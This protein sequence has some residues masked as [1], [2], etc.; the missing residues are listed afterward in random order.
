MGLP[1]ADS[2]VC[3]AFRTRPWRRSD[4]AA[5]GCAPPTTCR[6]TRCTNA[7][8]FV[9][10]NVLIYA[11]ST[12]DED[13]A[14]RNQALTVLSARDLALS[15]QV[16]QEF[17]VQSTR[18]SRPGALSHHEATSFVESLLR[19]RVQE[20]TLGV[21]RAAFAGRAGSLAAA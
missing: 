9:D 1:K 4:P 13:A 18:Q 2:T 20:L 5:A 21:L 11:V 8:R 15:V 7:M 3:A 6:A 12:A 19:F 14:K 17:Y 16:L 10:T